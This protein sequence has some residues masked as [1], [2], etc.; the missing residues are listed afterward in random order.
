MNAIPTHIT[1]SIAIS[2]RF[3]VEALDELYAGIHLACKQYGVDL[4]G[5][6]RPQ[7]P[8]DYLYLSLP[9]A[10]PMQIK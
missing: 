2:N 8:K 7:V 10:Q 9:L 6:I 5:A 1:Y 4:V 3:S